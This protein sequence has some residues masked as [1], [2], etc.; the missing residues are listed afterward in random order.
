MGIKF[1]QL[2]WLSRFAVPPPHIAAHTRA[3]SSLRR[4]DCFSCG[5]QGAL[6]IHVLT[7]SNSFTFTGTRLFSRSSRRLMLWPS[8]SHCDVLW[9]FTSAFGYQR[10]FA[11]WKRRCQREYR[12]KIS[13][14][15]IST[16]QI[17]VCFIYLSDLKFAL[18]S[19]IRGSM[20]HKVRSKIQT[21]KLQV[22]FCLGIEN[23]VV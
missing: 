20:K 13:P 14:C 12:H 18:F 2:V 11:N 10:V 5:G 21:D 19:K 15:G 22:I 4:R 3:H 8:G 1:G 7:A 9:T 6:N 17:L 23:V 16:P